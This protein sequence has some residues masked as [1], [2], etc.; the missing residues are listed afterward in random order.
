M[1]FELFDFIFRHTHSSRQTPG[2]GVQIVHRITGPVVDFT[3]L[4]FIRM[5]YESLNEDEEDKM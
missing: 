4:P 1:Y 2:Y 3:I 5:K